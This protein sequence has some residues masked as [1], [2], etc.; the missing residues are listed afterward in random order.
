MNN[1]IYFIKFEIQQLIDSMN[2]IENKLLPIFHYAI[3]NINEPMGSNMAWRM[4]PEYRLQNLLF[5]LHS[6]EEFK[7]FNFTSD[8]DLMDFVINY[9]FSSENFNNIR[10]N[11]GE[12]YDELYF[13][14]K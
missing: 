12:F 8:I 9:C 13:K 10:Y 14:H 11:L 4:S 3:F 5:V 6:F 7:D 2:K 1:S